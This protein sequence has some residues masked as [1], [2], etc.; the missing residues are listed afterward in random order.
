MNYTDKFRHARQEFAESFCKNMN[1]LSALREKKVSSNKRNI[2]SCFLGRH[3]LLLIQ[4]GTNDIGNK[5]SEH[6]KMWINELAIRMKG[7][8]ITSD[9]FW[10]ITNFHNNYPVDPQDRFQKEIERCFHEN[11]NQ[12]EII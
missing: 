12:W 1:I 2:V 3:L 8:K 5:R 10:H 4:L 11:N 9:I 6:L 7:I